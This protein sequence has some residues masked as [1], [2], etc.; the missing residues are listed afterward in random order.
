MVPPALRAHHGLEAGTGCPE[1]C[2]CFVPSGVQGL[3]VWGPGQLDLVSDL[4]T[5]LPTARE[6]ELD[7]L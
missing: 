4:V 3:V 5:T 1:S 2:G 6:L 7:D